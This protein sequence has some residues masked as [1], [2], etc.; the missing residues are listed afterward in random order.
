[1]ASRANEWSFGQFV[2]C[3]AGGALGCGLGAA[4]QDYVT[5]LGN[6][7]A[8]IFV[9]A[10]GGIFGALGGLLGGALGYAVSHLLDDTWDAWD[11]RSSLFF[12]FVLS[13]LF[14]SLISFPSAAAHPS[15]LAHER[16]IIVVGFIAATVAGG[17]GGIIN[18]LRFNAR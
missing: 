9:S 7:D 18:H 5:A 16:L 12:E 8:I 1:M 6:F 13:L 14:F 17:L 4:S 15:M 11:M 3:A 10:V 2:G